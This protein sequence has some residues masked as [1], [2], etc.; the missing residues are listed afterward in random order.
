MLVL[1]LS[2]FFKVLYSY[3]IWQN[4]SNNL[5]SSLSDN[6]KEAIESLKNTST[7]SQCEFKK[8]PIYNNFLELKKTYHSP[9]CQK[10]YKNTFVYF[11]DGFL[12]YK[13]QH[14]F[15]KCKYQCSYPK[16]ESEIV[17]GKW[18]NINKAK[19]DCDVFEVQCSTTFWPHYII[20][21]DLFIQIVKRKKPKTKTITFLKDFYK[22]KNL[23]NKYNVHLIIFDSISHFSFIRGLKKTLH[24]LETEYS[25]V[26]FK[27][28]NKVGENSLPNGYA[29]LLNK[30]ISNVHNFLNSSKFIISDFFKDGKNLCKEY[31]D[32]ESFIVKY[33]QQLN[34][35]IFNGEDSSS[36]IFTTN[37]CKGFKNHYAQHTSRPYTLKLYNKMY[38]KN[39]KF[40]KIYESKC[41]KSLVYQ[42]D[43]LSEFMKVYNDSKQFTFSWITNMA[44]NHLTG[45]YEYDDYLKNFFIKNKVLFNNGFLILMADHGF[46]MGEYRYSDIGHYESNNP[47]L[48]ISIPKELRDNSSEVIK[49]LKANS[50]KH[51]S[52]YDIYAT[53]LDIL[54]E[55]S[56][57]NFKNMSYFNFSNIIKNDVIKGDSLLREINKTRTCYL[58]KISSEFCLC[59][60][61]FEEYNQSLPIFYENEKN[62]T[63]NSSV[64]VSV[65]KKNFIHELNNQLEIGNITKY[66]E[67]FNEKLGGDF[68]L[69]YIYS[70]EKKIL[71]H[72]VQD[73]L[74]KGRFEGYFNED[75][76]ILFNTIER[77]DKYSKYSDHCLPHHP[78]KKFCY[79][80]KNIFKSSQ[81]IFEKGNKNLMNFFTRIVYNMKNIFK[82]T[83]L[84]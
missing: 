65:L 11:K 6:F 60:E 76:K 54:T 41:M 81:N 62:I 20:F 69:K 32:N 17:L 80:K 37:N 1:R 26:N 9:R 79:C 50:N 4:L 34:Y 21:Q 56:R 42:F 25:A 18:K 19:P 52:Q 75:G 22:N 58:M 78:Y 82:K 57:T 66:C 84:F 51:T 24:Y 23:N 48:I 12:R 70:I 83:L 47:F 38:Y 77:L 27:L 8:F 29:F 49:N 53:M 33:Y 71:F 7:I 68:K 5:N 14:F 43:Y 64:I 28:H 10:R 40:L 63:Y 13:N 67:R 59:R 55:G 73:V 31:L 44:H 3:D 2:I 39:N 46:R 15:Y 61:S 35:T 72:V 30:Q 16:G 36:T 45:H 74:P